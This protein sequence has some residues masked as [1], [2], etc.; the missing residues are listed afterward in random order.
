[1][2][3]ARTRGETEY[4][5]SAMPLGGYVKMLGEED[6]EEALAEPE[7]AFATQS[8]PRRSAIVAAGPVMNLYLLTRRLPKEQF[9][10]TGAWFFFILN[11]TKAPVYAWYGLYS[12]DSLLF[13]L[14]MVP[15]V[16]AG[17]L[18]G[19]WL[20]RV[21][22]Q[23]VFEVSVIGLTAG[24]ITWG[25]FNARVQA[26]GFEYET[27]VA[28]AF[29]ARVAQ[30][31][32]VQTMQRQ[33]DVAVF[34]GALLGAVLEVAVAPRYGYVGPR[35][36]FFVQP[37]HVQRP[38]FP[39]APRAAFG[40]AHTPHFVAAGSPSRVRIMPAPAPRHH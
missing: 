31:A 36:V 14:T 11:L 13:N 24:T 33:E 23:R 26:K 1:M 35:P 40:A 5:L 17:A 25:A 37:R 7:R 28:E 38:R 8:L 10:A 15:I 20:V 18:T 19:R 12:R 9:V 2:L 30:V 4:A 27:V 16:L 34:V 29:Q 6:E 21:M 3:F 32:A 22:P 39:T